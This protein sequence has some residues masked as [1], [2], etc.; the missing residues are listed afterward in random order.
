MT[1]EKIKHEYM[2][3]NLTYLEKMADGNK[4][5][6]IEMVDIFKEQVKE[7]KVQMNTLLDKK[8]WHGLGKLAHKAKSSVSIV[9]MEKQASELKELELLTQKEENPEVYE[10][11]VNQFIEECEDAI[12]EL[13]ELISKL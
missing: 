11:Y 8:N 4:E 9:G 12:V 10:T 5:L 3:V 1:L 13:D 7:F 6:I 2:K